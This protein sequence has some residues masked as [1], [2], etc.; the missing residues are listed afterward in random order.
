MLDRGNS[1]LAA[2]LG[3]MDVQI[4]WREGQFHAGQSWQRRIGEYFRPIFPTSADIR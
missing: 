2:W 4:L 1:P 3:P